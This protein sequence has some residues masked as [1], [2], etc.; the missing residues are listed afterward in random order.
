MSKQLKDL[1]EAELLTLLENNEQLKAKAINDA[2][3]ASMQMQEEEA[4]L[5]HSEVFDYHDH[6]Y[7]FY[8][9][10]PTAYG[11]KIPENVANKLDADYLNEEAGKLYDQLNKLIDQWE[12]MTTDEQDEHSEIYDEAV[13]VCDKLA[14]AVTEQLRAYENIDEDFVK[15]EFLYHATEGYMAEWEVKNNKVIETIYNV[16]K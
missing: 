2:Y 13:E 4:K 3:D 7:S 10:T 16:Y 15:S 6:Y 12:N 8:L 1:T 14:E 11:S 9:S 5:M